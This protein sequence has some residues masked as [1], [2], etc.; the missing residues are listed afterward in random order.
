MQHTS[1]TLAMAVKQNEQLVEYI[2]V[3]Y[4]AEGYAMKTQ[5]ELRNQTNKMERIVV[6]AREAGNE[7]DGSESL[8]TR[9]RIRTTYRKILTYS[10]IALIV[11]SIILI[12]WYNFS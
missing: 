4:D 11:I 3:A 1:P 6:N 2:K 8:I 10:M 12:I 9:M 5:M 7:I